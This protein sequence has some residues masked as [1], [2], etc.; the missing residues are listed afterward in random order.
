MQWFKNMRTSFKILFMVFTMIVLMLAISFTG[1]RTS[2]DVLS[3]MKDT[4]TNFVTP[5]ILMTDAKALAFQ[6]RRLILS[7]MGSSDEQERKNY[8]SRINA[9]RTEASLLLKKYEE[10]DT[11]AEEDELL[12]KLKAARDVVSAKRQEAIDIIERGEASPEFM[13]R[14]R[15]GGDIALAENEYT[16]V[17]EKLVDLLVKNS[18]EMNARAQKTA[19]DGTIKIL[20]SSIAAILIGVAFGILISRMITTPLI[21]I[22]NSVKSFAEGDLLSTFETSGKDE[23][24]MIGAEL[25][26]MVNHLNEIISSVKESSGDI[27]DTAQEFSELAEKTNASVEEFRSN[28]DEMSVNLN[29]LASS[30]EEV[31]ASVEEIAAGATTT[32]E[33]GTDIA[34][35]V[36]E[37]MSA[38][39]NGMSAVRRAVNGI[40]GVAQNASEAAQSVQELGV[41]TRQIQ[42]FV[43]QIGGIADQTNLLALNAAIEAA[44]AGDAGRGF[45]VVAEE[46]RKLAEDSNAAAK[47]IEEL[48]K[49][50]T[51]DLDRV[52]SISLDNAKA[53]QEANSLSVQTEEIISSI[54]AT[55]KRISGSTQDLAAVSEEQAASS[56]EIAMTVQSIAVKVSSVAEAGENIRSGIGEV[57]AA[58]ER[59]AQ[60]AEGLSGLVAKLLDML[61]FFRMEEKSRNT[62]SKGIHLKALPHKR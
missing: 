49:T 52:V 42:N 28:V 5:A 17:Y 20:V 1:Y 54:I 45:A 7:L 51:S 27:S 34:R 39:E 23:I 32:A 48:A 46:V 8:I 56:G 43:S 24:A 35:Q 12:V 2:S 36:D 22:R 6:N 31:N 13:A 41:R 38:G 18:E 37:A 40:E 62:K 53:S 15:T 26:D 9:N 19:S 10:C 58:S 16:S 25:Q 29:A 11:S 57:A 60:G 30:G 33:K 55:L 50:I 61:E 59:I 14:L 4:Y 21:K 44:R 47:N 3:A